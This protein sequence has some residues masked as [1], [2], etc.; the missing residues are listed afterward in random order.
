[1]GVWK[2][3]PIIMRALVITDDIKQQV[4]RVVDFAMRK[5]N[6]FHPGA[7]KFIP[8]NNPNYTVNILTYRCVFT[9]SYT[10][11]KNF[12]HLSV[13]VPGNKYPNQIA[14]FTIAQ[15]FGFTGGI[16][17]NGVITKPAD[18]WHFDVNNKDGCVVVIQA[19]N[20]NAV[21]KF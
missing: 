10:D 2:Q 12:R 3:T 8:G 20:K 14:V 16:E 15:L 4:K 21:A 19:L 17:V 7:S 11:N 13:S 6:W 18:D 1:M 9:N 5:E